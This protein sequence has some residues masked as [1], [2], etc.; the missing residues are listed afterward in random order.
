MCEVKL[1][2]RSV[3]R[4]FSQRIKALKNVKF[5]HIIV[6]NKFSVYIPYRVRGILF[7]K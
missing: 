2:L 6:C 1:K 4:V 5:K 7:E 3:I